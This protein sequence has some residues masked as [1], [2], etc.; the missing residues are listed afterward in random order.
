MILCIGNLETE[1]MSLIER[2]RQ[3]VA[4]TEYTC[5]IG[6]AFRFEGS[7]IDKLYNLA[8]E[9]L[10]EETKQFYIRTGKRRRKQ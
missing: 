6:F 8:D 5:S 3:E 7:T 9:V 10:Y 1:V 2:I 4:K